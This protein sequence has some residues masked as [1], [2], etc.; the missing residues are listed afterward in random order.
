MQIKQRI[1]RR[2]KTGAGT[3]EKAPQNSTIKKERCH[4]QDVCG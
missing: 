4:V 1:G 3:A 2:V